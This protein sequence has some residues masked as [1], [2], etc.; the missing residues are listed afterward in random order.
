[1]FP[2]WRKCHQGVSILAF[3]RSKED[4]SIF[5]ITFAKLSMANMKQQNT[6]NLF[7]CVCV[8]VCLYRYFLALV[9]AFVLIFTMALVHLI[10]C[11]Y[12]KRFDTCMSGQINLQKCDQ[13]VS[14]LAF[15]RWKEDGSIFHITF[16]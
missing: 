4:S 11:V 1:M 8:Y 14:I 13:E 2:F 12:G 6:L 16:A 7:K 5:H 15:D 9:L 10:H 3:D